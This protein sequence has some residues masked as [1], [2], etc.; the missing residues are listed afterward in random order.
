MNDSVFI[1]KPR[2]QTART[3]AVRWTFP[4]VLSFVR[5]FSAVMFLF[6]FLA[7]V[8]IA[9]LETGTRLKT[10]PLNGFYLT[11]LILGIFAAGY[12]FVSK[13]VG[14]IQI[15]R[16]VTAKFQ[17]NPKEIPAMLLI[18]RRNSVEKTKTESAVVR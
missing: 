1:S 2:L 17:K 18:I 3:F 4:R 16:N 15:W 5:K 8:Q 10:F 13:S 12:F 9:A 7:G 11:N 14:R 6:G